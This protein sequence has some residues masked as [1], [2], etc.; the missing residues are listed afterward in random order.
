MYKSVSEIEMLT[1]FKMTFNTNYK[2]VTNW[3]VK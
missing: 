3:S 2:I 1:F